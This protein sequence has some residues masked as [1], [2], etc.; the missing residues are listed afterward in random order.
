MLSIAHLAQF[1]STWAYN[2]IVLTVILT[3]EK[4]THDY[5]DSVELLLQEHT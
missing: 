3:S 5:S 1:M 4:N 2:K